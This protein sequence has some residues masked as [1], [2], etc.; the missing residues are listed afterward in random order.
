MRLVVFMVVAVS[1]LCCFMVGSW[2]L[3]LLRFV[4][5]RLRFVRLDLV[6]CVCLVA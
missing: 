2:L 4:W 3:E 5:L 1:E 6:L